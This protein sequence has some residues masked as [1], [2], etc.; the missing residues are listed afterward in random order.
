VT[1]HSPGP[2]STK[3]GGPHREDRPAVEIAAKQA[4]RTE[5]KDNAV[6]AAVQV[7]ARSVRRSRRT[8][9]AY[10]SLL[11]SAGRRKCWWYLATCRICGAPHL[12]RARQ[13]EDVTGPRRLPCGHRV[14]I[15]VARTYGQRQGA[16]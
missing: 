12:G 11:V 1:T 2:P 5:T 13:L 4:R 14:T 16:A 15:M 10:V 7:P 8:E 3:R 6:V 9:L